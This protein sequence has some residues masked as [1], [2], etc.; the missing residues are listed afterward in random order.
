MDNLSARW[1]IGLG[2][3]LFLLLLA[4]IAATAWSTVFDLTRHGRLGWAM[5][6][7]G[8]RS[9]ISR[10]EREELTGQLMPGDEI[11]AVNGKNGEALRAEVNRIVSAGQGVFYSLMVL[12]NGQS[13]E[14]SLMT[15][16]APSAAWFTAVMRPLVFLLFLVTALAVF[17]LKP[18]DKQACLLAAMLGTL[19]AV[20]PE[21][22]ASAPR[23]FAQFASIG[24]I[25]SA[26]F[27]VFSLHFFLVFPQRSPLL[28]RF[29]RLE[30]HLYWPCL[31]IVMPW[32]A[33]T[34]FWRYFPRLLPIARKM[35]S[36]QW[37]FPLA[38]FIAVGY[39]AA[40]LV[41]LVIGYRAAGALSRRKLHVIAAGSG[42]GLLNFFALPT[43]TFLGVSKSHPELYLRLNQTMLLTMPLVPLSFAY[44]IVKHQV[45]PVGVL[46]RRGVRYLLVARGAILLE[47]VLVL[48]VATALLQKLTA[49][50]VPSTKLRLVA[51]AVAIAIWNVMHRFYGRYLAPLI[52][53]RFF[54]QSYD[55]QQILA[56]LTEQLRITKSLPDLVQLVGTRIQSALQTENLTIFLREDSGDYCSVWSRDVVNR[57]GAQP[58]V[59]LSQKGERILSI[60]QSGQPLDALLPTA[61]NESGEEVGSLKEG[62]GEEGE[63]EE[64]R[65]L[66]AVKSALLLP[67]TA[68]EGLMGVISLGP[69]LG[70]LPFSGEDKKLLMSVAGSTSFA[71]ENV[72]LIERMIEEARRREE[73]EA[74]NEQRARELEEAR[75][76]QIS[77][78]PKTIPTL[79][80][81]EIAAYMKTATEVGGD[82]YD[83]HL[84]ASGELTIVVGDATGHGLKAGTVVT[85]AKSLF[86][87]LA[88]TPDVTEFFSHSSRAL[89]QMN[90]R[91]LFMAMTVARINGHTL[92]V[93]SAGM[94]PVLIYRAATASV[95]EVRLTG[96]PLGSMTSYR[97][98]QQAMPIASGDVIVLMSDGLPE[99]F[100]P[101]GEMLGYDSPRQMLAES[102]TR[103][104]Q[105]IIERM[106]TEAET[107]AE[108]RPLEDDVTFV[109]VKV[110]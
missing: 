75:Q 66:R 17:L 88:E 69:R 87:H 97:Y 25:F 86:N 95:E 10:L 48:F 63:N 94:P 98:R 49:G 23:A 102:A 16:A 31:L 2:W 44:A 80:H 81:L 54:R 24:R 71:I 8:G 85:A 108:G 106:I 4:P 64:S 15:F 27:I 33:L 99:R 39:M 67:L 28:R 83:F 40:T 19:A 82:Y 56:E 68:N 90:L 50:W 7:V 30:R 92:T 78:L 18:Y 107:W 57:T 21:S 59:W 105:A 37:F 41:A 72:R 9:L 109:V 51:A 6:Q 77:M 93:S 84:S 45:I 46:L 61:D 103:T 26:T 60:A 3:F 110:R 62:E 73:V 55:A 20:E 12:R 96:V 43:L 42:L 35:Y 14:V 22:M 53:R 13:S 11:L 104:A 65:T 74:E 29:P 100:N 1:R 36:T 70:D 32:F 38:E 58:P 89:K 101:F 34:D 91:S 52:D 5:E 79:P 76:L 47:A